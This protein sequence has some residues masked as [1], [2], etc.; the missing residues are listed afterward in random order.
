M[1]MERTLTCCFSGHRPDK[2]PW[3]LNERDPRCAALK[4][5][6]TREL[7]ARGVPCEPIRRD[8]YTGGRMTFFRDPDGL[9]LELHE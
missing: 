7:E 5:S 9:P 4:L 2:L 6:L 8:P 3:G 1:P